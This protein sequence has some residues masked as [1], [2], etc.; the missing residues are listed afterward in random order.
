[1]KSCWTLRSL[2][3]GSSKSKIAETRAETKLS[4][5][6]GDWCSQPSPPDSPAPGPLIPSWKLSSG[7]S[8][9]Q[10]EEW[11]W[12]FLGI[13]SPW[14]PGGSWCWKT[15][16]LPLRFPDADQEVQRESELSSSGTPREPSSQSSSYQLL[17]FGRL[18]QRVFSDAKKAFTWQPL[19]KCCDY[20]HLEPKW[21]STLLLNIANLSTIA[22]LW[23]TRDRAL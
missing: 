16:S 19:I 13:T 8:R 17:A 12:Y 2:S 18:P 21:H 14:R 20:S 6:L 1:M 4:P 22:V 10:E 15:F 11:N 9:R 5:G 3:S 23:V 7:E